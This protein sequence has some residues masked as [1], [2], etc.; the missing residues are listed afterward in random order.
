M[1]E[2]DSLIPSGTADDLLMA[3]VVN[4]KTQLSK[5]KRQESG[6]AEFRPCIVESCYQ[7]ESTDE[8]HEIEKHLSPVIRRLL[9]K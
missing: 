9:R 3:C 5:D 4:D 7:K 8:Q 6:F 2:A 1:N